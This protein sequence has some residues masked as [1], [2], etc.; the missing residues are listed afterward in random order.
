[1]L[2]TYNGTLKSLIYAAVFRIFTPGAAA[3]RVPVL[4]LGVLT[5]WLFYLLLRRISCKPAAVAGCLLLA[6]DSVFLLTTVFDWG[7]VA[8]QHL[9]LVAG[10][11]LLMRFYQEGPRKKD[12][13]LAGGAFLLGLAMWDKALAVWMLSG[14]GVAGVLT[15][16]R[17]ILA[18]TTKRRV[19]IAALAFTLG[20]L[21]LLIYN[22]ANRGGTFLGNYTRESGSIASKA[23]MLR[24]TARGVGLLGLMFFEDWQTPAPHQPHGF[25]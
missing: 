16:P 19:A 9:L 6:T 5:I 11:F 3:T 10:L 24:D 23:R 22:A 7:P 1:M 13:A 20:A 14:I 25:A 15:F 2:S 17:Q 8:L 21:P 18:V 12:A 4:L